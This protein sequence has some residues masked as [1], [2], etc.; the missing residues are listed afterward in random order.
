MPELPFWRRALFATAVVIVI[1][2]NIAI[3]SRFVPNALIYLAT[4]QPGYFARALPQVGSTL[5]AILSALTTGIAFALL[6]G[7][8]WLTNFLPWTR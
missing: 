2:V 4:P 5:L 7:E 3:F 1:A 6:K 8:P